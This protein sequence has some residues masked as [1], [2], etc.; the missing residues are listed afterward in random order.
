MSSVLVEL[1][2]HVYASG[3]VELHQRI[4]GFLGR[5]NDVEHTLV[6]A[7]LILITRVLVDVRRNQDGIALA[8]GRQRDRT[9][10]LSTSTLSGFPQWTDRSGDGRTLSTE[11][12]SFGSAFAL[13]S[14]GCRRREPSTHAFKGCAL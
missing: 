1:D 13:N 14:N 3:E 8:I 12:E 2:L 9:T 5:L 7:N 6:S 10:N 11:C 4:N